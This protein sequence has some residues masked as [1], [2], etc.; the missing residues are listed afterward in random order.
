MFKKMRVLQCA[1][2]EVNLI[3]IFAVTTYA[4]DVRNEK[5]RFYTNRAV[6]FKER[7]NEELVF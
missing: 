3:R 6:Y 5:F 7:Q 2:Y 4:Y 1:Q